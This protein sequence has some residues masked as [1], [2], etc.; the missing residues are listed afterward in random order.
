[1]TKALTVLAECV[2]ARSGRRF[3][4]GETFDPAPTAEQAVRLV[5]A[6]CLPAA[7]IEAAKAAES[8]AEKKAEAEAKKNAKR[9]VAIDE[10]K[11]KV[12]AARIVVANAETALAGSA[13]DKKDEATAA[14][15]A[16]KKDH[17][18]ANAALAEL[19]K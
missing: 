11:A 13:D 6:G 8:D 14:L 2:D 17:A 5:K 12:D 3:Q 19:T 16:A 4:P 18:E 15:D 10:A 9:Q 7:A 1:M